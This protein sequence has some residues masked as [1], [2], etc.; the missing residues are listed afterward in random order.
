M[1]SMVSA[2]PASRV[3]VVED[4]RPLL[5]YL[6]TLLTREYEVYTAESTAEA[7]NI[8]QD[9]DV[10]VILCD[11][12]MPGE[13]GLDFLSRMRAV[14]PKTQRILLTGHDDT[15]VFLKA[16][17]EG[18]VL[19]FLVKP[20]SMNEIRGAVELGLE[21]HTRLQESEEIEKENQELHTKNHSVPFMS[22]RLHSMAESA[23]D[24][25]IAAMATAVVAGIMF[26]LCILVLV[27]LYIFK[28]VT[29]VDMLE[30]TR[31]DQ[32]LP[33]WQ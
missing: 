25:C 6:S 26:I 2:T 23:W 21:E 5:S 33:F 27:G 28:N 20:S 29:G 14:C 3:L 19:K 12:D 4:E 15:D 30:I 16:I 13:K 18:D 11:H 1:S 10:Q 7:E 8:L 22:R 32:M 9:Q 31:L 24:L 17:N